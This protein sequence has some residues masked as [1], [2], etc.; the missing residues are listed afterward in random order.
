MLRS[1]C[2]R[3]GGSEPTGYVVAC[4]AVA[5]AYAVVRLMPGDGGGLFPVLLPGAVA[6]AACAG[7]WG[8]AALATLAGLTMASVAVSSDSA[9]LAAC[10]ASC[11]LIV[12]LARLAPRRYL[13]VDGAAPGRAEPSPIDLE[14]RLH[15]SEARAQALDSELRGIMDTVPAAI[16]IARDPECRQ[17]TGSR[18]SYEILRLPVA[19]NP[20]LSAPHEERPAHFN[21]LVDGRALTPD[22]LPVQRAAR[23]E[24]IRNFEEEVRFEDG[25]SR[26]LLGNAAP[27]RDERGALSGAVS[28]FIDITERKLMEEALRAREAALELIIHR[29]PFMLTRCDRDLRYVFV[30]RAYAEML[31]R[32]P[33]EIVGRPIVDI[34]GQQAFDTLRPHIENVLRGEAVRFERPVSLQGVGIRVLNVAYT[35]EVDRDGRIGGWIGSMLD[36]TERKRAEEERE[37]LLS[38][39]QSLRKEAEIANRLKD[40]F[41]ATVSHELRTPLN[42]ILG[43]ATIL[44]SGAAHTHSGRAVAAIERNA[45]SQAQLIED[46]LDVSSII[47]GRLRLDI[48]PL[49]VSTI[50]QAA[51]DAVRPAADAKHIELSVAIDP[52]ADH[53]HADGARLQQVVWNLLSNS[54]KFTPEQGR[55]RIEARQSGPAIEIAVTDSGVGISREFLPF[56]FDRF[57]QADASMTRRFGGLGLGLAIARH[58]VEMHGGT[59]QASSDGEGRGAAFTLRLPTD[60]VPARVMSASAQPTEGTFRSLPDAQA[61]DLRGVRVLAVDDS[62]DARQFIEVLLS[63]CGAVV[64]TAASATAGLEMLSQWTPDVLISDIGLPGEDGYTFLN[65]VRQLGNGSSQVPAIA[66]SGY[67]RPENRNRAMEIGFQMFVAKPVEAVE[68]TRA[69]A[70]LVKATRANGPY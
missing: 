30:S 52:L 7:G 39:E 37:R 44:R 53:L 23:G 57:R 15:Q 22:Q 5:V 32:S 26:Y 47:S 42:A 50:V 45:R 59:I 8:P 58:L 11:I 29:T 16:W 24:H 46:L 51:V 36:V 34:V 61:S 20:S 31:G 4:A 70:T 56:V 60:A 62:D 55:I 64:R 68:L 28:A 69:I 66:L 49:V 18:A 43:W 3:I 35:P 21:V 10:A 67:T 9:E 38:I 6:L 25:S 33:E 2:S 40:E 1:T 13:G 54:V 17:I 14:T 63:R 12:A 65:R 27:L 41:L 19:A 48:Q